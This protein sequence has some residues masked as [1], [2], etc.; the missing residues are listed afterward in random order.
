MCC[1]FSPLNACARPILQTRKWRLLLAKVLVS[2]QLSLCVTQPSLTTA[3]GH[4]HS[5]HVPRHSVTQMDMHLVVCSL[6][7]RELMVALVYF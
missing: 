5:Q 4:R 7:I 3:P 6:E 2:W 1:V